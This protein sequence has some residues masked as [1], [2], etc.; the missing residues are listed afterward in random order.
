MKF[1]L[2]K[3]SPNM[4]PIKA[5]IDEYMAKKT[6]HLFYNKKLKCYTGRT[7]KTIIIE[8]KVTFEGD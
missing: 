2:K 3:N 4:F 1:K 5:K 8:L 7:Q 6:N